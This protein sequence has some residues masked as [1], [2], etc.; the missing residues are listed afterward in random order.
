MHRIKSVSRNKILW[1]DCDLADSAWK[2]F[3]GIM[4]RKKIK[5]PLLFLLPS[6]SRNRA[7]IHS[8]FCIAFDA[9]FLDSKK[10]VVDVVADIAPWRPWV[11]PKKAAKYIIEC[12]AGEAARLKIFEGEQLQVEQLCKKEKN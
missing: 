4:F 1:Q 8:F 6:E 7:A 11:A 2:R 5:K 10:K 12:A 9:I 3:K